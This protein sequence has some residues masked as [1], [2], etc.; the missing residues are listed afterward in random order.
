MNWIRNIPIKFASTFSALLLG[1]VEPAFASDSEESTQICRQH[2]L[3]LFQAIQGYRKAHHDLPP[4][5][6]DLLD[7][8]ITQPAMVCPRTGTRPGQ[9]APPYLYEFE[10]TPLDDPFARDLKLTKADLRR[11]QMSQLG[12]VVPLLRCTNHADVIVVTFDGEVK[13]VA[14]DK[15]DQSPRLDRWEELMPGMLLQQAVRLEVIRIPARASETPPG[16][17]DLSNHYNQSLTGPW[18]GLRAPLPADKSFE[19][20]VRGAIQLGS[21]NR[22]MLY[23]PLSVS[24]IVVGLTC[25]TLHFLQGAINAEAPG[26]PIGQYVIRF[27]DGSSESIPV[28]YGRHVLTWKDVPNEDLLKRSVTWSVPS[29]TASAAPAEQHFAYSHTWINPRPNVVVVAIDFISAE[30]L[31][32]PF[33]LALTAQVSTEPGEAFEP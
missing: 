2:L 27:Q 17:V 16:L 28:V 12:G 7:P 13:Q 5:L 33:L 4:R 26:T 31:S 24:N 23:P 29:A 9:Q 10:R 8:Q 1:V 20:D 30:K 25:R 21:A 18:F 22:A 11:L 15:G 32:A 19:W 6:D 3:N 14:R